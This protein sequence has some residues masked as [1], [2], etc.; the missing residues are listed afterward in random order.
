M[1][2]I[3]LLECAYEPLIR[4]ADSVEEPQG[5]SATNLPG[6]T[7]RDLM[8]HLAGDCQRALVAVATPADGGPDTDEISYGSRWE[9]GTTGAQAGLRGTRIMASAWTSVRGPAGLYAETARAVLVAVARAD[10]ESV[11]ATQGRRLTV[12]A[13]VSTLAVE[14]AV[15]QLDLE[16][17]L[18]DRPA[19]D[20][21]VEVRRVLDGLLGSQAP[22][23]W[24][25]VRYALVG[26]GR[27]QLN[28]AE[29]RELGERAGRFPLFG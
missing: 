22:P 8:F 12:R 1:D 15:H 14:A 5:W 21:L 3:S 29:R 28:D 18:P 10:L 11:V 20:V 9:P 19:D 6:W 7:A 27:Q 16:P 25:D 2:A 24:D 13:L 17:V 4:F 23:S 26:T